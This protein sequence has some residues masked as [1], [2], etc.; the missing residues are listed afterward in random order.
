MK[1]IPKEQLITILGVIVISGGLWL[2]LI[3]LTGCG[4]TKNVNKQ[5]EVVDSS[6]VERLQTENEELKLT[7]AEYRRQIT[8]MENISFTFDNDCPPAVERLVRVVE[9]SCPPN[10]VD[11]VKQLV[12]KLYSKIKYLADGSYEVQGALSSANVARQR[13]EQQ[14]YLL[15]DSLVK[16]DSSIKELNTK[17]NKKTETKVVEK[18]TAGLFPK[19]ASGLALLAVV[20]VLLLYFWQKKKREQ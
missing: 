15:R 7:V 5:Q 20:S 1:T 4:S 12:A 6:Y 18:T 2:Y 8:E 3:S 16:K 10:V 17:L 11:S 19:W 14:V 13:L 9:L